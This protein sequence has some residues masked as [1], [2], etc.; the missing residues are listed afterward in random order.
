[1]R[2]VRGCYWRVD[3]QAEC[4]EAAWRSR[5]AEI[6]QSNELDPE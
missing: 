3:A 5:R 6:T 4:V 2:A 1:M